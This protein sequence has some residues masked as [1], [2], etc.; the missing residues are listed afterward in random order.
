MEHPGGEK[1][2]LMTR[3]WVLAS[4]LLVI[5]CASR[6]ARVASYGPPPPVRQ[7]TPT[8]SEEFAL[9]VGDALTTEEQ[10]LLATIRNARY[11]PPPD[12]APPPLGT[13]LEELFAQESAVLIH[14]KVGY[15]IPIV[16]ND[17]VVWWIEYFADRVPA[18]FERYL[19]R[20]GAW[21]PYLKERLREAGLPED[22]AYLAL[23]ESG[24]STQALSHAGAVGPWQFMSYTGREY[25]L[26]IDRWVDERRDYERSTDA[27]IAYLSD[28]HAWFGSW[29]LAAA[30]YNGGQGRIGRAMLR[31][32]TINFWELTGIH[33]ETKDY[34]P[35]LIAATIVAKE[36]EK[37]GYYNVPYL[38]PVEWE[39]VTVPTST[40]I[41]VVARAAQVPLETIRTLNPHLL[42]G[43]TPPGE[44]NF[45]VKIPRGTADD[46]NENYYQIPPDNRTREPVIHVV[47]R[48][49]TLGVIAAEY[50]VDEQAL[51][52][53][54]NLDAPSR[55]RAGQRLSIPDRVADARWQPLPIALRT[56]AQGDGVT[57]SA[58]SQ[59]PV[60][61]PEA[62]AQAEPPVVTAPR[63]PAPAQPQYVE[64]VVQE[65]ETVMMIAQRYGI[66]VLD[67]RID[68]QMRSNA[69]R[70]GQ[71]LRIRR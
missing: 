65:G 1:L 26:R 10:E 43:R 24:F 32:N 50:G 19:I 11:E 15:D 25:G 17:R 2:P 48:G 62:P 22:L 57:E 55:L 30:G 58:G 60:S 27:A 66:R 38:D 20:S 31:D 18:T 68:N 21:L 6:D 56:P 12:A 52:D 47:R 7:P 4:L 40:D 71:V 69:I 41:E 5:G 53:E 14:E 44:P 8:A 3:I 46:F 59:P 28:L 64:H 61:A 36:P 70:P 51:I 49:E 39:T 37:Y 67:I 23:I 54:N 35:K 13:S 29:Y 9:I 16:L 34:V 42:R 45:P 63:Q 33:S